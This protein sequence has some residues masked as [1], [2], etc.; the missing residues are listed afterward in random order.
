MGSVVMGIGMGMMEETVYDQR[1]GHPI[2]NNFA[3]YLVAVN[4]DVPEIDCS[5]LDDPDTVLNV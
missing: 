3:D 5:F 4:A 1:T 2:N